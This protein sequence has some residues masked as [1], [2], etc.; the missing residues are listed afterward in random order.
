[1]TPHAVPAQTLHWQALGLGLLALLLFCAGVY[2][3]TVTGFDSRFVL[4]AKEMLRHGPGFFPTTYGQP[5]ADYSS[6]STLLIYLF[7][8]PFGR[9]VSLSAW[10]PT[11]L[12][13][14]TIVSLIYRLVAPC[15]RTWALLSVA[16]LLLSNTFISETRAVS[17]DQ[18]LAALA[19]A[20]FYLGYAHD[21]F[22]AP[23]RLWLILLLLVLGFA[24]RGPIGLVIPTGMLCS[25]YLL[26]GQWRR[27]FGFGCMA[28]LLLLACVGL[29]LWLARLSGGPAFVQEVIRMQFTGRMDGSEGSSGWFF[30]FSS[31]LGNYALAYPLAILAWIGVLLARRDEPDAALKLLRLCTAAGLLVMIG[32][33]IPQAKKARYLLP[34]LP[35]AAI[36]AAYPFQARQGRFLA[37]LRTA[38]Q[39]IWLLLPGLLIGG[40]LVLQRKFPEQL[41]DLTAMLALLGLLQMAALLML[42]RPRWRTVGLAYTAV[43]A[44]WAAYIGV[45][46]PVERQLYDTRDFSLAAQRLIQ[47]DPSPLV[48]HAM[49]KDAKAIKFMV[50]LDQDLQPLFTERPEALAAI[51]GPAWVIMDQSNLATLKATPLARLAPV[52]SGRFDKNDF[53]MLHLP[54]TLQP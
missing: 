54:A 35:M 26:G 47:S 2:Q 44:V 41:P 46:E 1:M 8:L 43:L 5:Y 36:V 20:V 17:L 32:L 45:F 3:Q 29:L 38:I 25:Y 7:S 6:A 52:L 4:F 37:W 42:A 14:A 27:L 39:G 21:H 13:S 15:S 40:L 33:S 22:A 31:S 11:A 48:L 49:G 24:I 19:L 23:R 18:I 30:Y 10:L 16:L 34:M 9:V 50:N 28:L 12:A 53:V 51:P